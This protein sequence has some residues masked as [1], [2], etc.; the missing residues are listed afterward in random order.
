[1]KIYL[2]EKES[3]K[4][5]YNY[6][7]G[8]YIIEHNINYADVIIVDKVKE[9]NKALCIIDFALMQ[10]KEILCIKN[11]YGKEDYVCNHLIKDGAGYV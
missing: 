8:R 1:M 5:L 7:K 10:G 4:E 11:N 3:N 9:I 6:L 2:L